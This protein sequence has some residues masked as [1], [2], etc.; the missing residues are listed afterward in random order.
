MKKLAVFLFCLSMLGC[1]GSQVQRGNGLANRR[2]MRNGIESTVGFYSVSREGI[3][4]T[5]FF[6]EKNIVVTAKH[7]V[8]DTKTF[9]AIA[10][11]DKKEEELNLV[12]LAY[13][14]TPFQGM[15][16][17]HWVK[18]QEFINPQTFDMHI[19]YI[20][21]KYGE[22]G[23][24]A[25]DIAV[26]EV[27]NKKDFSD[28]HFK[29]ARRT[30][31]VGQRVYSFGMPLGMDWMVFEG[32][33]AH[34]HFLEGKNVIGTYMVDIF[35]A[36]GCSGGPLVDHNGDVVGVNSAGLFLNFGP[37]SHLAITMGRDKMV[38][39]VNNAKKK[40]KANKKAQR[41]ALWK[42]QKEAG[43]PITLF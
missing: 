23:H 10:E 28:D 6:V 31:F 41:R 18:D 26:L 15:K 43:Q 9:P 22:P 11:A 39:H 2:E 16:H 14:G 4:C 3:F 33:I 30:P 36:P 37:E 13:D 32:S 21:N 12:E 7:C 24:T 38:E 42:A 19:I 25:N 5:G 27:R 17:K 8:V 20:N 1:G 29:I 34:H 40:M 35:I